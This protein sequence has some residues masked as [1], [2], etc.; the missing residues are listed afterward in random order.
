MSFAAYRIANDELEADVALEATG[1]STAVE[2]EDVS[3][4]LRQRTAAAAAAS[5]STGATSDNVEDID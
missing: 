2:A 1:A 5:S 4:G 3:F